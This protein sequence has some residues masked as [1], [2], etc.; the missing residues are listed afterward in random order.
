MREEIQARL[1]QSPMSV[2]VRL[3][4][5]DVERM[6]AALVPE[7]SFG[8]AP[9]DEMM[10]QALADGLFFREQQNNG[11]TVLLRYPDGHLEKVTLR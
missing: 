8:P 4:P 1:K 2:N 3:T 5:A 6:S 7:R 10:L 9:L 11:A